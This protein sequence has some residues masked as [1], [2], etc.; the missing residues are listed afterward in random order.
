MADPAP[1][2]FIARDSDV[3]ALTACWELAQQGQSQ[4]VLLSAPRY[5]GKRGVVSEFLRQTAASDQDVLVWRAQFSESE[6]GLQTLLRLY[7]GLYAGL[8]RKP[9]FRGKVE[10]ALNSEIP[11][12]EP[13]VQQWYKH[14][15]DALKTGAPK[16]GEQGFQVSLPRDN[17]LIA[18]VEIAAGIAR[19]FPV[20]LEL[21]D[22]QHTQSVPV[23]TWLESMLAECQAS[24]LLTVLTM[25]P[26]PEDRPSWYSY[27]LT[28]FLERAGEDLMRQEVAPWTP[29]EVGQHLASRDREADPAHLC[30]VAMGRP[31]LVQ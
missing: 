22:L 1:L 25:E 18:L 4:T 9:V 17:P 7:A 16:P 3:E 23:F 14:F 2:P 13:R 24:K 21:Q 8:H 29:V 15:I 31:L 5:G 6:N 12:V 19:K 26:A 27:P 28:D 20:L 30:E 11:R 10:M